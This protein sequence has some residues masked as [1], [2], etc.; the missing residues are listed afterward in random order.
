MRTLGRCGVAGL[1]AISLC[2]EAAGNVGSDSWIDLESLAESESRRCREIV[3]HLNAPV[4]WHL[5]LDVSESYWKEADPAHT[6]TTLLRVLPLEEQDAISL[7]LF[8]GRSA[9]SGIDPELL[10]AV[11]AREVGASDLMR[12]I[13]RALRQQASTLARRKTDVLAPIGQLFGSHQR[14]NEDLPRPFFLIVSDGRN[15]PAGDELHLPLFARDLPSILTTVTGRAERAHGLAFVIDTNGISRADLRQRVKSDWED[16]WRLAN[17]FAVSLS[18]TGF[19][20]RP[21]VEVLG[22]R[23]RM[24][25]LGHRLMRAVGRVDGIYPCLP[26]EV[27]PSW[28][29]P[30]GLPNSAQALE[31]ASSFWVRDTG[32]A[33]SG[34]DPAQARARASIVLEVP[35]S[36][37]EG[38]TDT[39]RIPFFLYARGE[40][41]EDI[42]TRVLRNGEEVDRAAQH[43]SGQLVG[44]PMWRVVPHYVEIDVDPSTM[45]LFAFPWTVEVEMRGW[46]GRRWTFQLDSPSRSLGDGLGLIGQRMGDFLSQG[47]RLAAFFSLAASLVA[48]FL[49]WLAYSNS[50]A[51]AWIYPQKVHFLTGDHLEEVAKQIRFRSTSREARVVLRRTGP[52][53]EDRKDPA[54]WELDLI[55]VLGYVYAA[56]YFERDFNFLPATD[57]QRK[58]HK[59]HKTAPLTFENRCDG[60][61]FQPNSMWQEKQG[62]PFWKIE[63]IRKH[64]HECGLSNL[65]DL[66]ESAR[67]EM[68]RSSNPWLRLVR[69]LGQWIVSPLA[70]GLALQSLRNAAGGTTDLFGTVFCVGSALAFLAC[71]GREMIQRGASE[72][73]LNFARR[74]NN[75]FVVAVSALPVL[76]LLISF[77]SVTT[78]T[79]AIV[80]VVSIVAIS[81]VIGFLD[82]IRDRLVRDRLEDRKRLTASD[83][84]FEFFLGR[85]SA[86]Y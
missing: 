60:L 64:A 18:G 20:S 79:K 5:V 30:D 50:T 1:L 46:T 36:A 52:T 35:P 26:V 67:V 22:Q 42:S 34:Q 72:G 53:L 28:T 75:G 84:I 56:L 8:A 39:I 86:L 61:L 31:L 14:C 23:E 15:E 54:K 47:G 45:D 44:D 85:L 65:H 37:F 49:L 13:E 6:L 4:D 11:A 33:L 68:H 27:G 38:R 24:V 21:Q 62:K 29:T 71:F 40:A 59:K 7:D 76:A 2:G 77:F 17:A 83:V 10:R 57:R 69:I 43:L 81:A 73:L 58:Q 63:G 41:S 32:R 48:F 74:L 80:F 12:E 82:R 19:A 78:S 25:R 9:P 70:A 3:S 55:L 66:P 16:G 51:Q